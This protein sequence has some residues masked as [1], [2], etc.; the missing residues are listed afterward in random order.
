VVFSPDGSRLAT[1][2]VG[3]NLLRLWE[4]DSGRS[5][6]VLV[7]HVN[8]VNEIGFTRDGH[9]VS[10]SLDATAQVWDLDAQRVA[11]RLCELVVPAARTVGDAPPQQCL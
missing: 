11:G 7:G 9:L 5:A 1:T 10:A 3:D 4:V 2:A 6:G 8:E